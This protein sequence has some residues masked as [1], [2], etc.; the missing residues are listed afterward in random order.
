[1]STLKTKPVLVAGLDIGSTKVSLA[2]AA[3]RA[4]GQLEIIGLG[5]APNAG[6]RHGIIINIE[7]TTEAI[8]KAKEEAELMAGYS[9]PAVWVGVS[10]SHIKSF[11]SKGMVAIKEK[12]VANS[13]IARVIEAAQAVSV[14]SDRKV[15]H[16][17]PRE[18][19]VDENDGIIDPIGMTGVRLEAN[20]HIVTG[21]Q[22][23]LNNIIKCVEKAD[24]KVNGLTLEPLAAS[25]V[26]L[27]E[28]EKSLGCVLADMGGGAIQLLYFVNGSVAHS[29]II[30]VGGQHFTHDVAVGLRTPQISAEE[31]KKRSGSALPTLIDEH[32]SIEVEGVGGR[33]SRTIARKDLAHILEA[34]AEETLQLIAHDIKNSGFE[35]LLGSGVI[36]TGGA[37]QLPGLVEMGEY[38]M[39][40]PVR[41]G[42]AKAMGPLVDVSK[43]SEHAT[44]AGLIQYGYEKMK[45]TGLLNSAE[46]DISES[47]A[48]LSDKVKGFFKDL[49]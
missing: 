15:L 14:P 44:V 43:S 1:M 49:F 18:Y 4:E 26:V 17:L 40:L 27:S 46:I 29:S 6:L 32:D 20:V 30:S 47:W 12:E 3:V 31:L 33:K 19:K 11:D 28:D 21:G 25:R 36:L 9:S 10:G 35:P 2:I 7:A 37:S 5:T 16:V 48:G 22:S 13:D 34:R 39:D 8:L 24:L 42:F 41:K 38:V 45:E 23:A